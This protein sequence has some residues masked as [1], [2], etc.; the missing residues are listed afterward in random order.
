M[1]SPYNSSVFLERP[2]WALSWSYLSFRGDDILHHPRLVSTMR[3][4]QAHKLRFQALLEHEVVNGLLLPLNIL[5]LGNADLEP[6]VGP[7][8]VAGQ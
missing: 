8:G 6:G 7:N 2:E 3:L 5:D 1:T 4:D